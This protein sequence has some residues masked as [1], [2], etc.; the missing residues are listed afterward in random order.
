MV[1]PIG[2]QKD[3]IN[4]LFCGNNELQPPY[5]LAYEKLSDSIDYSTNLT[6]LTDSA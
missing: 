2:S 6:A 1:Y 3:T 5:F 4:N